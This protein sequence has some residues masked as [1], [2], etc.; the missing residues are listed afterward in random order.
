MRTLAHISDL[1]FGRVDEAV[2]E[3]LR[4]ALLR[5]SPHLLVVSGDLTQRARA[6]QFRAARAYL[7][8]LP[9]PQLVV[10]GNHD[11]PLYNVF[12]RFL[13][14]LRDYRRIVTDE[15]EPGYFDDEL[16]VVGV[17][18][19]R[20]LTFKGGRINAAQAESVRA[21][22]CDL[23]AGVTKIVV[24]HHPFHV[25]EGSG[26]EGQIVG[27]ARMALEKLAH[28]GAD[29]LL[30][31]HLHESDVGHTAERYRIAGVSALVVQAG[32]ATSSRTR[33]SPNGFNFLRVED[34]HIEVDRFEWSSGRFTRRD[35]EAFDH[36]ASGWGTG[37]VRHAPA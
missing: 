34:N 13:A 1:H 14:P 17:N 18:T 35:T 6:A 25:P 21:R 2:L 28:C 9:R 37:A 8:T 27:R 24:T 3:P 32:T 7:D 36:D 29:L 15:L 19:A 10:P 30:S 22:L 20:S 12:K 11:V 16:A 26:E 5:L 33:E 4:E 23:P 31:G